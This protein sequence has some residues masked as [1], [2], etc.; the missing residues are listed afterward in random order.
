[1]PKSQN[2]RSMRPRNVFLVRDR[3]PIQPM[4]EPACQALL[5]G[6]TIGS[7]MQVRLS[8]F[9]LAISYVETLEDAFDRARREPLGALVTFDSLACST[10]VLRSLLDAPGSAR[11]PGCVQYKYRQRGHSIEGRYP[12]GT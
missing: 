8:E 4:G 6:G 10:S 5:L 1:M 2:H 7:A 11:C 12:S 9:G 3:E